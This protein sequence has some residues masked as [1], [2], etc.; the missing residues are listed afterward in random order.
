M[1]SVYRLSS[2]C[3]M[4]ILLATVVAM[5]PLATTA[6]INVNT[7]SD[8]YNTGS[9]C[10]LR[11]AI[12]SANTNTAFGG[13][14][15]GDGTEFINLP[16]GTYTLTRAGVNEDANVSG[17]LDITSDLFITGQGTGATINAASIDRAFDILGTPSVRFL[18]LTIT[19]GH[20]PD[21][22]D[23]VADGGGIHKADGSLLLTD[24]TVSG[25][26]AGNG[27]GGG[28]NGAKGGY[29][30]GIYSI[31]GSLTIEDS[32]I[33]D[34]TAGAGED[35]TL[36]GGGGHGGGIYTD[37]GTNSITNSAITNNVAGAG[38]AATTSAGGGFGGGAYLGGVITINNSTFSGNTAGLSYSTSGGGG[39]GI[40]AKGSTT[41][42]N[43]TIS[44]NTGGASIT[45]IGGGGGGIQASS[46]TIIRY[47]TITNNHVGVGYFSFWGGGLYVEGGNPTTL[48]STIL[49]GNTDD[50]GLG[51]DCYTDGSITSENYNVIGNTTGCTSTW[52][53]TDLIDAA[54][55]SLN[56]TPLGYNQGSTQTHALLPGSVALDLIPNGSA[57]CGSTFTV[58]QRG[59]PRPVDGNL[60]GLDLCDAGA[61]ERQLLGFLPMIMK[62][63]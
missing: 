32:L 17:D 22:K 54:A 48:G 11:E 56:L 10:S 44:G 3:L 9:D 45:N 1:K 16:A 14:T 7:F 25:N 39:G 27:A 50:T 59:F 37:A 58:D 61:Y 41:I 38:G 19:G 8:E 46:N 13:C 12:T 36:Y 24:V 21:G 23:G 47:S 63:P 34:N 2:V 43:S 26:Q 51:P 42:L 40:Y 4:I 55:A 60:D 53:P 35:S 57:G 18:N 28:T 52:L 62:L 31:G 30:G 5:R 29:G 49:A 15:A 20:S 33:T 6:S